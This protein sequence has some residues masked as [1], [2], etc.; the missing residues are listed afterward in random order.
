M[1]WIYGVGKQLPYSVCICTVKS[2]CN[3]RKTVFVVA[4]W[5][6]YLYCVHHNQWQSSS[7]YLYNNQWREYKWFGKELRYRGVYDNRRQ[8]YI[9]KTVSLLGNY[10]NQRK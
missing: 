10:Y 4:R 9:R 5:C 6:V 7:V 2:Q 3:C 8:Q 1:P